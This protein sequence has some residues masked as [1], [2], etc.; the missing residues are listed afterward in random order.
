M[1]AL[2]Y[3][4]LATTYRRLAPA[5][6]RSLVASRLLLIARERPAWAIT[7]FDDGPVLIVAPHFD[8]EVFGCGGVMGLH[9]EA[10]TRVAVVF[11]TDG[12]AGDPDLRRARLGTR[13]LEAAKRRLSRTREAESRAACAGYGVTDLTMLN[14]P[15]GKL[16]PTGALV[17]A[18]CAVI[19]RVGPGIIYHP[20]LLDAHDDHWASNRILDKALGAMPAFA[21]RVRL[22]GYEVW[23]PL[24]PNA[25][26]DITA[27]M[28]RKRRAAAHFASQNRTTEYPRAIEALN[29]Y[30]SIHLGGGKGFGEAF[31]ELSFAEF[32][33]LVSAIHAQSHDHR[34][35]P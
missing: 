4:L 23:T 33:T 5:G 21:R 28:P 34:A 3:R 2:V 29:A 8:D 16:V 10:G 12:A 26:A 35:Q 31:Q 9:I 24:I 14:G 30:R 25:V 27:Q 7:R 17:D 11:V 1:K 13:A 22:R 32:R 18:L 19:D 20:S 15:D 6:A